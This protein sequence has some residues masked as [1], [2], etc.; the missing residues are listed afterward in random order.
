[1]KLY[2]MYLVKGTQDF[3]VSDN[4]KDFLDSPSVFKEERKLLDW[5]TD[6]AKYFN[7]NEEHRDK[8]NIYK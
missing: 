2:A 1:M 3:R 8:L 5:T 4:I 7:Y 6:F